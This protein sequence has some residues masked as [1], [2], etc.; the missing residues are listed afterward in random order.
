M[1]QCTVVQLSV[2]KYWFVRVKESNWCWPQKLP[3]TPSL[4]CTRIS[5]RLIQLPGR[6]E[7]PHNALCYCECVL[8]IHCELLNHLLT[9]A[10]RELRQWLVNTLEWMKGL[11][12]KWQDVLKEEQVVVEEGPAKPRRSGTSRIALWLSLHFLH[13][14]ALSPLLSIF[15]TCPPIAHLFLLISLAFYLL[16]SPFSISIVLLFTTREACSLT[17]ASDN[18]HSWGWTFRSSPIHMYSKQRDKSHLTHYRVHPPCKGSQ[19]S[20]VNL[21]CFTTNEASTLL[22]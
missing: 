8:S 20:W 10:W 3:K 15:H 6:G 13:L 7:P 11:G 9:T 22:V 18:W 19:R 1:L 17:Q 5:L 2:P 4:A 12:I 14:H 21:S 16:I